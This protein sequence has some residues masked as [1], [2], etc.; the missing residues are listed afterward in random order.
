MREGGRKGWTYPDLNGRHA[1]QVPPHRT[2][3]CGLESI[4]EDLEEGVVE[5]RRN[6]RRDGPGRLVDHQRRDALCR[7]EGKEGGREGGREGL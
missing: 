2:L 1:V 6:E 7:K 4:L 5:V 3:D